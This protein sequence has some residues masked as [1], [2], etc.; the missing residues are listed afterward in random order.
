[1]MRCGTPPAGIVATP[2]S[3][4]MASARTAPGPHKAKAQKRHNSRTYGH[5]V[6]K[7]GD[8]VAPTKCHSCTHG[9]LQH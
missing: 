8:N 6:F 7:F 4:H 9:E 1:M 5:T 2:L 3:P